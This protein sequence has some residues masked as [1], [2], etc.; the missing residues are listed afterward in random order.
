VLIGAT[1]DNGLKVIRKNNDTI[2]ANTTPTD[3]DYNCGSTVLTVGM[4]FDG[5][6]QFF[7]GWMAE[8]LV[9]DTV[10][11]T[12]DAD[13]KQYFDEKYGEIRRFGGAP[14][15]L[16]CERSD[17]STIHLTWTNNDLYDAIKILRDGESLGEIPGTDESFTDTSSSAGDHLY[18]LVARRLSLV[19]VTFC[20]VSE[21]STGDPP[22]GVFDD[23]VLWLDAGRASSGT[24]TTRIL[25]ANG[26]SAGSTRAPTTTSLMPTTFRGHHAWPRTTS[27]PPKRRT[28]CQ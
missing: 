17:S 26:S 14:V 16:I 21:R 5:C 6:C 7:G 27:D 23:L 22:G 25:T 11:D 1:Y 2:I 18:K 19:A 12:L 9:Y 3:V 28:N 8:I 24:R 10:S 15:D 4:L 20:A 13:V